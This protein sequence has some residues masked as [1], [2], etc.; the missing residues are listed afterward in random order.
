[1]T[2]LIR[3]DVNVISAGVSLL[4]D[5]AAGQGAKVTRVDWAPPMTG[6]EQDLVTVL[7]DPRRDQ[8][9]A[10]AVERMFATRAHLVDVVQAG[11]ALDLGAGEFLHA[12]PPI[13]WDRASGPMRGALKGA[14]V[15]EG[16]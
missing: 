7:S 6:T 9:N 2:D 13:T 10:L 3:R 15:F 16:L 14:A 1:M 5:A 4:A 8:A 12:G 11:T